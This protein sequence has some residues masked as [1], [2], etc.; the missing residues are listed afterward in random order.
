MGSHCVYL[1]VCCKQEAMVA[2]DTAL[3]ETLVRMQTLDSHSADL[4]QRMA[5]NLS[6]RLS[7]GSGYPQEE[8]TSLKVRLCTCAYHVQRFR[9]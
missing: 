9:C 7:K 3:H 5:A 1:I 8:E 2:S 6:V 4:A